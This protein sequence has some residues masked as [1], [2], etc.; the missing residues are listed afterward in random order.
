MAVPESIRKDYA[1]VCTHFCVMELNYSGKETA[2]L[3]HIHILL[4]INTQQNYPC[5][6]YI[7]TQW[8]EYQDTGYFV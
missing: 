3:T 4:L 2:S 5:D 7:L 8:G 6:D 1:E